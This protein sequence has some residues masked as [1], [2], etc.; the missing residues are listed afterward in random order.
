MK[1]I[2]IIEDNHITGVQYGEIEILDAPVPNDKSIINA[3]RKAT[4]LQKLRKAQIRKN[5]T[6][7]K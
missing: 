4:E 6:K 5:N 3:Y 2:G 1:V 7:H